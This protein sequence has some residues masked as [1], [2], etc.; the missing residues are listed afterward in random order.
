MNH[1]R[2][3]LRNHIT[4]DLNSPRYWL[5][6]VEQTDEYCSTRIEIAL[7]HLDKHDE[8]SCVPCGEWWDRECHESELGLDFEDPMAWGFRSQGDF[9][10]EIVK[11]AKQYMKEVK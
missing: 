1:K 5:S 10:V 8:I 2:Q 7:I 9:M 3:I 4:I 11:R 6:I